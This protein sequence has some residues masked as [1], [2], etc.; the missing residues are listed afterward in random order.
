MMKNK[1]SKFDQFLGLL[2]I[3]LCL[4]FGGITIP[5]YVIFKILDFT[6]TILKLLTQFLSVTTFSYIFK[7]ATK[8]EKFCLKLGGYNDK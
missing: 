7:A 6:F 2:S 5:I 1:I 3:L 8:V 4:L